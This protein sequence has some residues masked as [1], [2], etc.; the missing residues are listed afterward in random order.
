MRI[1]ERMRRVTVN[2]VNLC[3]RLARGKE[4][5]PL[6]QSRPVVHIPMTAQR[7]KKK[8]KKMLRQ[9]LGTVSGCMGTLELE[10][11]SPNLLRH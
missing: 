1:E 10:M 7:Q 6:K 11:L 3:P 9:T 8:K 2:R 4:G 5:A